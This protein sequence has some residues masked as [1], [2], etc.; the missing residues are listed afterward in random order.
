MEKIAFESKFFFETENEDFEGYLLV[1][2]LMRPMVA[3]RYTGPFEMSYPDEDAD[4]YEY[5]AIC[6]DTDEAF[7]VSAL[8]ENDTNR[9]ESKIWENMEIEHDENDEN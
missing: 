4:L 6:V 2:G 5:A 8:S 3:G 9:L 1:T 7:D